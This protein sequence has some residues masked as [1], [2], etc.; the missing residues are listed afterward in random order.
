MIPV[1]KPPIHPA[2]PDFL[3]FLRSCGCWACQETGV[4]QRYKTEA[5]H[6][7]SRRYG[8]EENAIPLC[9]IHHRESKYA[10]HQL[11]RKG[12]ERHWKVQVTDLAR[13][14]WN[15]YR[16]ELANWGTVPA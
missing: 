6:I 15:R 12:F 4:V 9:G 10:Y 2:N 1:P 5:A 14:Y 13:A 11:G 8:D 7:E 16:D 3:R